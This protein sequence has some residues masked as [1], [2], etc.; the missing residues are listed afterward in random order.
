MNVKQ[1]VIAVVV[2][3]LIGYVVS[4]NAVYFEVRGGK[5]LHTTN[6]AYSIGIT[7]KISDSLRLSA[8]YANLGAPSVDLLASAD[9][10]ADDISAGKGTAPYYWI[11]PVDT[12]EVYVTLAKEWYYDA[13]AYSLGGGVGVYHPMQQE[14]RHAGDNSMPDLGGKRTNYTPIIEISV[15]YGNTSLVFTHQT[16]TEYGDWEDGTPSS[17]TNTVWMWYRF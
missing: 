16:I 8:G 3:L 17:S 1:Y 4:A 7:G 10:A 6:Q 15:G 9:S 5:T 14:D 2:S 13:W 12:K 11:K